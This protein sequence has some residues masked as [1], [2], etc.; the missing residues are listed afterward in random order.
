MDDLKNRFLKF[1]KTGKI[2]DYLEYAKVK[3]SLNKF[4]EKEKNNVKNIWLNIGKWYG[5][6]RRYY[7]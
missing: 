3:K 6:K 1:K 5:T 2:I 4:D 7:S